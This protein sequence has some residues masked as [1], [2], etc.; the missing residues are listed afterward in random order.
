M[1]KQQNRVM[2]K[3]GPRTQTKMNHKKRKAKKV[4]RLAVSIGLWP[5]VREVAELAGDV[6]PSQRREEMDLSEMYKMRRSAVD[7][8]VWFEKVNRAGVVRRQ[9]A[10][11]PNVKI[12]ARRTRLE[13][14]LLQRQ[15][16]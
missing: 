7:P 15:N 12:P 13:K 16:V 14:K 6:K 1:S 2:D 9:A 4:Q 11:P 5:Y 10:D 8:G 3:S